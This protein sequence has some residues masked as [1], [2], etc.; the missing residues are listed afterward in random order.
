M[1]SQNAV[2]S[3]L[4][5]HMTSLAMGLF[6]VLG[7][8]PDCVIA[9]D[10]V[11]P[12]AAG[13]LTSAE[14][15]RPPITAISPPQQDFFSKQLVYEGLPVKASDVV[16]DEAFYEAHDRL[17]A[18]LGELPGITRRLVAAGVELHIIGRAQVTT[19]LP[20]WRHDKGR[21]LPEYN[22]LTRDERTRGMGG[23]LVSCG[24]ENLLRLSEDRYR[25]RDICVH[26]FAHAVRNYGM[27]P[28]TRALF[29]A[30]YKRS[31]AM[32]RWQGSY[33]GSN[34]DEF[35]AELSMWYF[36]AHGDL[37]MDGEK[38]SNGPEGLKA[39]DPQAHALFAAFY[40]GQFETAESSPAARTQRTYLSGEDAASAVEW[41]F[42]CTAGR[43]S[44]QWSTIPVPSLWD[45]QS[46]GT[47]NYGHDRPARLRE[48]GLYRHEFATPE[49]TENRRTFLVF[50]GAMTDAQAKLN[51][52]LVGPVHRGGFCEFRYEVTE[53]LRRD[54]S[55]N[56]LEV[57]VA[58]ESEDPSVNEA[59]RR[60]DYWVFGGI[61]RPVWLETVPAEFIENV[62]ID[63][64]ADG[65]F[66]AEVFVNAEE[67][68]TASAV[69]LEIVD[70]HG[71]SVATAA[72]DV[73]A[74]AEKPMTIQISADVASVR[75]WTAETPSL[76]TARF[77]LVS[78]DTVLH[79]SSERFGF[80]TIEV[81]QGDGIFVNGRRIT[82]KGVN[83]HS[84]RPESGRAL[85]VDQNREDAELLKELNCNAVRTSHYPPDPAFLEAA[86]E[87]G[88]YVIDELPGW[89]DSY[90]T[91]AGEPL[92]REMVVRDRNHPSIIFW[93][94]GNEGGWNDELNDDFAQ[95]DLQDRPLLHTYPGFWRGESVFGGVNTRHY[96]NFDQL[97]RMLA[98]KDLVMP[99]EFLH[100][101]YDGGHGA[102]LRDYWDAIT[103][104]PMGVGG[105]L[106]VLADEG[107]LRTGD[108]G[109]SFIDVAG[110]L[111]PDGLVG[112][113]HEREGSFDAVR[114]IYSPVQFDAMLPPDFA[115]VLPIANA[116][117][118]TNLRDVVFRWELLRFPGWDDGAADAEVIAQGK[119]KSPD[120]APGDTG[121]L[122]LNLPREAAANALAVTVTDFSGRDVGRWVWPLHN[123]RPALPETK[124]AGDAV[125]LSSGDVT[126]TLDA[127][128]RTIRSVIRGA[129]T[130]PLT[131]GPRLALA[132]A[133]A[134]DAAAGRL[135]SV[136]WSAAEGGW[137]RLQY[138]YEANGD[139]TFA[140]V[141]FDLPPE[142]VIGSRWLGIGPYRVWQNRQVGGTLGVW[143]AE[144]N[145]TVTGWQGWQYP[146]F[147]GFFAGVRWMT[148][149]LT[150]GGKLTVVPEDTELYV[151]RLKPT[152]PPQALQM[153]TAISFPNGDL[154]VLHEI[155]AI[156]TK[157]TAASQLGPQ[158]QPATVSGSYSGAIWFHFQ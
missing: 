124:P 18:M 157:F 69:M 113:R 4:P 89:Q 45:M 53:L 91:A 52:Q 139:A 130:Y 85:S 15:P 67:A 17:D 84:F 42:F 146:E 79:E 120:V 5:S 7:P 153:N 112:P 75:P 35:F 144:A 82:L 129:R 23:R 121:A 127:D 126:L 98:G 150:G 30:Q 128:G 78:H 41:E 74:G 72:S 87:L 29:D 141:T 46:F 123:L 114:S 56:M 136:T 105:F 66:R 147:R 38:P 6:A 13:A 40:G 64:Q 22:G 31:L 118:F 62:A 14:S 9:Q 155:P 83:R 137:F 3:S 63:A 131:G 59:E 93:S 2:K 80:R 10:A 61:F 149:N 21:R 119:A 125:A 106:W 94:N 51:G 96:P 50:G 26:E 47:L 134:P 142:A 116:Y 70:D 48:Q 90:S 145:D 110:N 1:Q 57:L 108:D 156:G 25:G 97:Q 16:V 76:Y 36:G 28:S 71:E 39:Y 55:D 104:S 143:E 111:A 32:G 140:G 88:L 151:Q 73:T 103:S 12:F 86:D 11:A 27:K 115:G 37:S 148:L 158:S 44:G 152:T 20:E 122:T 100:G 138:S 58:K 95:W 135:E 117:D 101:L 77:R 109:E 132:A 49:Q 68:P 102:G 65:S 24:E 81:R 154:S 8:S 133:D 54:G 107:V 33:A 60:A 99:T 92:V 34:P 43:N 19:D